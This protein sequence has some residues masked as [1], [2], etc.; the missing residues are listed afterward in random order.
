MT[1]FGV[2]SK[3]IAHSIQSRLLYLIFQKLLKMKIFF[4]DSLFE[5]LM[6]AHD[7]LQVKFKFLIKYFLVFNHLE[8]RSILHHI[9]YKPSV[10]FV[11]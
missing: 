10:D 2:V 1:S 7:A 8:V 9:I 11:Q 6:R 4:V 5:T 3:E